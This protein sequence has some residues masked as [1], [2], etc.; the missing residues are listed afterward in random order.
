MG[1]DKL[2]GTA[3]RI[4]ENNSN[5]VYMSVVSAWELAIKISIKKITLSR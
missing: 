3:R 5:S 2:S 1:E 4:I